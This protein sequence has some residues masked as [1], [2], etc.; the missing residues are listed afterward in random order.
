MTTAKTT[1]RHGT[2]R[3]ILAPVTFVAWAFERGRSDQ[4]T[5]ELLAASVAESYLLRAPTSA[6]RSC[7]G[8][9]TPWT[10]SPW[11]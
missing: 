5:A 9:G 3:R 4:V 11:R 10:A 2:W 7:T 8:S 1:K 6:S